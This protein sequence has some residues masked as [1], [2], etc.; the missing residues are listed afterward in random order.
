MTKDNDNILGSNFPPPLRGECPSDVPRPAALGENYNRLFPWHLMPP[1]GTVVVIGPHAHVSD[2][3]VPIPPPPVDDLLADVASDD[4]YRMERRDVSFW[5][6]GSEPALPLPLE[7]QELGPFQPL[8]TSPMLPQH[9]R[10]Y[11]IC[12]IM[13]Y[14]RD[15]SRISP[16]L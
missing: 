14:Y 1:T 3:D 12:I 4:N 15:F 7:V 11:T 5:H 8:M 6:R 13:P 9:P 16:T 2:A 10:L